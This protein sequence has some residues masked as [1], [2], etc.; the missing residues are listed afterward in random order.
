MPYHFIT[1]ESAQKAVRRIAHEQLGRAMANL[2]PSSANSDEAIHEARKSLK[3]LRALVRLVRGELGDEVYRR[4]N[5]CMRDAAREL[6]GL[7][8]AAALREAL[9]ELLA[10]LGTRAPKSRFE[11]VETWLAT[12]HASHFDGSGDQLE[13]LT[14]D[15]RRRLQ[16]L[17]AEVDDWPRQHDGWKTLSAGLRRV[18]QGGRKEYA[19]M[20]WHPTD[21][22]LHCWRKRVK[23]L[24]YHHQRLQPIWPEIMDAAIDQADELGELLG[25]DHDLAILAEAAA[26]GGRDAAPPS[27]IRALNR[28]SG[29]RRMELQSRCRVLG[30]R[31]YVERPKDFVRRLHGYWESWSQEQIGFSAGRG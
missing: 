23:Y 28:R 1:G 25:K 12:R 30:Q 13:R 20:L 5:E 10:W 19:E 17:D 14:S 29:E 15:V 27:T 7:R 2:D 18:F 8:D 3:R 6:A 22:A 31:I 9:E 26:S 21:E 24:R 16:V 11:S 4:H